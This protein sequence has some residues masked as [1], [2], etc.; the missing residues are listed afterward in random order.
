MS[1]PPLTELNDLVAAV[2]DLRGVPRPVNG[3]SKLANYSAWYRHGA[4]LFQA[5]ITAGLAVERAPSP[6]TA[7]QLS[8]LKEEVK[9]GVHLQLLF[10]ASDWAFRYIG[11]TY[12]YLYG[13]ADW[14]SLCTWMSAGRFLEELC[15]LVG[16]DQWTETRDLEE[17]MTHWGHELYEPLEAP[18]GMPRRHWWWFSDRPPEGPATEPQGG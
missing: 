10:E 7:E 15:E 11:Y 4:P 1:T 8:G 14:R 12:G 17:S 16:A 3:V 13:G 2:R 9:H 6:P 18:D 5:L